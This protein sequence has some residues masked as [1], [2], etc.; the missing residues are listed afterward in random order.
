MNPDRWRQVDSLLQAVLER[1][2]EER[3]AF[4]RRASAGDPALEREVRSLLASKRQAGSFLESPAIEL[5]ARVMGRRQNKEAQQTNDFPIGRT[6]SHFRI[7]GRLGGGGMGIVYKAEDTRLHRFVA[8]KF[9]PPEVAHDPQSLARF[10][11][12]AQA[13][14]ALNHPNICTI[15]DIGED[16]GQAFIAM[17]C[18]EGATLKHRIDGRPLELETL[19]SLGVE[20]ADALDAAHAKGIVHRDIKPANIFVTQR[21][22]AKILDFGLAKL[23]EP[24]A[25]P[26]VTASAGATVQD[27]SEHLTN[28]GATLGTVAY[29][30]PEQAL[31]KELD[32]RTDLFSFGTVLY[33]MA[34]GKLPFR[35]ETSA[36]I[37]DAILHRTPVPPLRLNPDIPQRLDDTI[38]KALEK[39]RKLR[40]QS[41]AEIRTDLQRLRRDSDSGRVTS[42]ER[43]PARKSVQWGIAAATTF[44]IVVLAASGWLFFSRRAH[45]LTDKDTIVLADFTNA[46]NDPVFDGALRQGLSVQ[47]EQSPFLSIISD[48]KIQQTLRLMGQK[49]DAK[50]TASLT[51][52]LCQRTASAAALEGS[53]AQ[54][55]SQY[56]L[57]LKAIN[58]VS[59]ESLASTEAQASDKNHVLDALGRTASEIRNKLGESLSTVQKLD[60]PLEQASTPSL[61]A[62]QAFS[63]G[64][65]I[66]S[67]AG[68]AVSLPFFKH[69][70]ELDPK[71]ALAYA[72]LGIAYTSIG[73]PSIAVGYT[74]KAYELRDHTSEPE[75]YFISAVFHKEVTGNIEKATES[76]K[77]WIQSYP[78]AEMPHVYLAGAI[79]P[80]IGQYEQAVE[81]AREAIR[82]KPDFSVTYAFLM[83]NYTSLNRLDEAK[84]AFREALARKIYNPMYLP[85]LYQIAFLQNDTAAM[86]Q[87]VA[88]SAGQPAAEDQLLSLQADTAAHSGRLRDARG[89]SRQA[90]DSAARAQEQEVVALYSA[91]STLRESLFGNSDEAK[92]LAVSSTLRS[93]GRDV[94]FG[95]AL[96]L[97]FA[98]DGARAQALADDLGKR[99]PEDTLVQF[100][101]L[102]T[103]R[104]TLSLNRGNASEAIEILRPT[105]P[106]ELGQTTF[107]TY[108]WNSMY[109][110]FVRAQAY[111]A[112]HQGSEAAL[113]FQKILDHPGIVVNQP[114]GALARLGLARAYVLQ[115]DTAKAKA[116]Y[117]D[118]LALWK[119]ADRDI[120]VLK[121]AKA[122]FAKLQ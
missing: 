64:A 8:L 86:A 46:T 13:A 23:S 43:Q 56:L 51:R 40:Y 74:A 115:G 39:D 81:D 30:S 36:A 31:G 54:I 117:Q 80:V 12:E 49:P 44:V 82:L 41:A 119:D 120:P 6:V 48:Q 10:R 83:D 33:E 116:A 108:G 53:I 16:G 50:L 37:F 18:L 111:L 47:L 84:A 73:E 32:A 122:E 90:M 114:I 28:T 52:E 38:S 11:R 9:L 97:A 112:A 70:I 110:V 22:V 105:A 77:L 58:C 100:N 42:H 78:R 65:K 27:S 87:Q 109:P 92:R 45:V 95:F 2:P 85:R 14:S 7:V 113:E 60:T 57:T 101:F 5:A 118:F 89:F 99:L 104:A 3:D 121:N 93:T 91:L 15:H 4:L 88:K 55:G 61:E 34:T 24:D 98:G 106:Y 26:S 29:M 107:S 62:L 59:G 102:P 94:Q 63:S 71:F 25:S 69:A 20:I 66:Q 67:T 96:A 72:R 17:E 1:S 103:L 19:L 79:Y 75:K 68:Q 21:G 35:G 76:C